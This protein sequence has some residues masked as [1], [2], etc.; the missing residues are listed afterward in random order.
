MARDRLVF[1]I[2]WFLLAGPARADTVDLHV[3]D[4]R[5]QSLQT[6]PAPSWDAALTSAATS[7]Y[8]GS[9]RG[10]V[11][12]STAPPDSTPDGSGF[13]ELRPAREVFDTKAFPVRVAVRLFGFDGD[14]LIGLCSGTLIAPNL[15]LTAAHCVC[16]RTPTTSEFVYPDSLLA[17]L[18]YDLGDIPGSVGSSVSARYYVP[19]PWYQHDFAGDVA[20]VELREPIGYGSGWAGIG[21]D[22]SDAFF[23]TEVFHKLSYPAGAALDDPS[24]VF[25]GT[26]LYYNYGMLDLVVD[27]SLGYGLTGIS[28]QSG[29]G[30]LHWAG[31]SCTVYGTQSMAGY[32]RH[33]RLTSGLFQTLASAMKQIDSRLP[34]GGREPL[35]LLRPPVP[36]P[37]HESARIEYDLTQPGDV[38]LDI[39]DLQGRKIKTL[40]DGPVPAGNHFAIWDGLDLVGRRVAS[41]VYFCRLR[42][43]PREAGRSIVVLP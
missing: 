19:E 41:G 16:Y 23:E 20:L 24:R 35:A 37:F 5:D 29:S 38:S 42:A 28:G 8:G 34:G 12:L 26:T 32:S 33:V 25:D 9:A 3:Y 43:G 30:L 31:P 39:F 10:R 21:F 7:S 1:F 22:E 11:W 15:V 40:V 14:D 13:T 18:A 17:V 2:L 27:R 6:I 4:V 36:N